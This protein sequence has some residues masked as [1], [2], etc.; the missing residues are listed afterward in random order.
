MKS[1]V[2]LAPMAGITDL[3][4]R[5]LVAE[6]GVG[7]TISEMVASSEMISARPGTRERAALDLDIGAGAV[8]LAGREAAPMG[9]A[10][11]LVADLGATLIDINMGCPAKKVTGGASG[12][13]LMR[14]PDRAL[15]L[16]EAVREASKLPVT[17]K[18]RLGWDE[19]TLNAPTLAKS[20]ESAGVSMV[21]IHGRTRVQFYKGKADWAAIRAVANAVSIPVIA[22]GDIISLETARGALDASGADGIMIGRGAQGAPWRPAQIAA[23]LAGGRPEPAPSGTALADLIARH[24]DAS[25]AF[26]GRDLGHRCFKKHL[27]WYLDEAGLSGTWRAPLLTAPTPEAVFAM[28]PDA[29]GSTEAAA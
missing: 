14:E 16:I 20:A 18:M 4:F 11:R 23:G 17:V 5:R 10:A 7:L 3:P 12:A 22:N 2:F 24:F 15:R 21:T 29:F 27:G 8:Q 19:T 28:L 9:E 13:A 6:F 25:L 26:Y 1:P